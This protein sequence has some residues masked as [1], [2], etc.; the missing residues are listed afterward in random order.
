MLGYIVKCEMQSENINFVQHYKTKQK[1][2]MHKQRP[3]M[4]EKFLKIIWSQLLQIDIPRN[5][6]LIHR[7]KMQPMH[8]EIA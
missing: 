3:E 1:S 5:F 8:H 7:I 6:I 2:Y 4:S